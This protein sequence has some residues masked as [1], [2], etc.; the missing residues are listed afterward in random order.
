MGVSLIQQA[1]GNMARYVQG[2]VFHS[3]GADPTRISRG[4]SLEMEW[5]GRSMHLNPGQ[6]LPEFLSGSFQKN[7][8]GVPKGT[9]WAAIGVG[10]LA[11]SAGLG[12][13]EGGLGGGMLG[14]YSDIGV[15]AALVKYGYS[16]SK[17][18]SGV[19][20]LTPGKWIPGLART[21]LGRFSNKPGIGSMVAGGARAG[22]YFGR[23]ISGHVWAGTVAGMMGGGATAIPGALLGGALGVKYAGR[24][25]VLGGA[26]YMG[27]TISKGA[28]DIVKAGHSHQ[29]ARKSIQTDG[30]MA[31]FMTMGAHTMRERAV[32]AIQKSHMNA[33]TALGQEAT[34]LSSPSRSY[35][36]SYRQF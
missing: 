12:Y 28:Y 8:Y 22:E 2:G 35:F 3:L 10:S 36:S 16:R 17:D 21:R 6:A 15:D 23:M 13:A 9:G 5:I 33:R 31:S 19:T 18:A 14:L 26:Y 29:Q 25:A 11:M 20:H 27:K 1:L 4:G 34:Y 32:Q 30:D 24:L 7:S